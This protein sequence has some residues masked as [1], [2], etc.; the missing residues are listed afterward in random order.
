MLPADVQRGFPVG[1]ILRSRQPSRQHRHR[2]GPLRRGDAPQSLP[3]Q[4]AGGSGASAA[5]GTLLR[6]QSPQLYQ[7][8]DQE[9]RRARPE[10]LHPGCGGTNITRTQRRQ[11]SKLH[12][13]NLKVKVVCRGVLSWQQMLQQ[14][15]VETTS[16]ETCRCLSRRSVR[17][18]TQR[19]STSRRTPPQRS[20]S[21]PSEK[22]QSE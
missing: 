6:A 19:G 5:V 17:S 13:A 2:E 14:K 4:A 15:E 18:R 22:P 1:S 8:R 16:T 9:Q 20:R 7:L 3:D 21:R 12:F 11:T 10:E